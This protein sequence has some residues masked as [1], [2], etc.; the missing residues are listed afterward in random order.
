MERTV[1]YLSMLQKYINSNK[2]ISEIKYYALSLGNISKDFTTNNMKKQ[3]QN[4][5]KRICKIFF[6]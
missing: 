4:R 6:C 5:I 1:S 3:K 2:I